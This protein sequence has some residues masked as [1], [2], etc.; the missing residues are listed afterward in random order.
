MFINSN[1]VFIDSRETTNKYLCCCDAVWRNQKAIRDGEVEREE[2]K[3][4]SKRR[5]RVYGTASRSLVSQAKAFIVG[6]PVMGEWLH[7]LIMT[8][9]NRRFQVFCAGVGPPGTD[10]SSLWHQAEIRGRLGFESELTRRREEVKTRDNISQDNMKIVGSRSLHFEVSSE[11]ES[12]TKREEA[13]VR[14][15]GKRVKTKLAVT[16]FNSMEFLMLYNINILRAN[17]LTN[18]KITP[19][20]ISNR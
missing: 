15:N 4:R 14:T 7:W 13:S 9:K 12:H 17:E 20:I 19:K 11:K 1:L 8:R 3:L 18:F 5:Y 10:M 2:K 16:Y 6:Q